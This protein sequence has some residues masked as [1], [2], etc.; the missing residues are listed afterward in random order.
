MCILTRPV[1]GCNEGIRIIGVFSFK[2]VFYIV[3]WDVFMV[4]SS[5]LT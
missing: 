1:I 4:E 2:R 3:G 5:Y